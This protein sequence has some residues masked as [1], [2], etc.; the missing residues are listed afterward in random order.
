MKIIGKSLFSNANRYS[1][2]II[3][4]LSREKKAKMKTPA[5]KYRDKYHQFLCSFQ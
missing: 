3:L 5:N 4:A 2:K 1:N